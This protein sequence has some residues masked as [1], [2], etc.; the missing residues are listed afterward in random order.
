MNRDVFL[1]KAAVLSIRE[2]A[3]DGHIKKEDYLAVSNH[4]KTQ[5]VN[6]NENKTSENPRGQY[7]GGA[8][9]DVSP[10][11]S[12]LAWFKLLPAPSPPSHPRLNLTPVSASS[13]R[14]N[15]TPTERSNRSDSMS[16]DATTALASANRTNGSTQSTAA[17]SISELSL[18]QVPTEYLQP[19]RTIFRLFG[20]K[21]RNSV[22]IPIGIA[23][24]VRFKRL[25]HWIKSHPQTSVGILMVFLLLILVLLLVTFLV[26]IPHNIQRELDQTVLDLAHAKITDPQDDHFTISVESNIKRTLGTPVTL[27][28]FRATVRYAP[29]RAFREEYLNLMHK[30]RLS[31]QGVG[32]P[33]LSGMYHHNSRQ[34]SNSDFPHHEISQSSLSS[35]TN[36][37]RRRLQED[38]IDGGDPFNFIEPRVYYDL[39]RMTVPDQTISGRSSVSSYTSRYDIVDLQLFSIFLRELITLGHSDWTIVGHPPVRVMGLTFQGSLFEKPMPVHGP[40]LFTT[41]AEFLALLE[42]AT[43]ARHDKNLT[44]PLQSIDSPTDK[45]SSTVLRSVTIP[46][47]D[48]TGSTDEVAR[49]SLRVRMDNKAGLATVDPIGAMTVLVKYRGQPIMEVT[50]KESTVLKPVSY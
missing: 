6:P 36:V 48:L 21:I 42:T 45:S 44:K 19:K 20:S 40:K 13:T 16:S 24:S 3:A 38:G 27:K 37:R 29:S 25:K 50:S 8:Q 17:D 26:I 18:P 10:N 9:I 47:V 30:S 41:E 22:C 1:P 15:E 2:S 34:L 43:D 39:G 12:W 35:E 11:G 46:L 4:P 31:S 28:E 32:S 49:V 7:G 23:V 14:N 33:K 5:P